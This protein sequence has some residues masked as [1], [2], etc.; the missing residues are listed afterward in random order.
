MITRPCGSVPEV[1]TENVTGY[2]ASEVDD[3]VAAVGRVDRLSRSRCRE[4]FERRFTVET[5][6]DRY[7]E[8][9]RGL[10]ASKN[11]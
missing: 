5:M 6:V 2:I 1:V 11:S 8:V 10:I 7:E 4:E 9:Y 3:L